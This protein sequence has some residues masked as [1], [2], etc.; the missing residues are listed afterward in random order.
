MFYVVIERTQSQ[1]ADEGVV[2]AVAILLSGAKVVGNLFVWFLKKRKDKNIRTL[3]NK[4]SGEQAKPPF[5]QFM[6]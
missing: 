3:E 4:Y 2:E 1:G 5:F 6:M